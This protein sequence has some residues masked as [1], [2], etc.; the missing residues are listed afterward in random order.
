MEENR[1]PAPPVS[2]VPA[3][4]NPVTTQPVRAGMSKGGRELHAVDSTL[5]GVPHPFPGSCTCSCSAARYHHL[6]D[7]TRRPENPCQG[8]LLYSWSHLL[9]SMV[10]NISYLDHCLSSVH[11]VFQLQHINFPGDLVANF[12]AVGEQLETA[13]VWVEAAT[14]GRNRFPGRGTAAHRSNPHLFT[15]IPHT[16]S[17][18][19]RFLCTRFFT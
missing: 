2:M 4:Y 17:F 18:V 1:H 13:A 19:R 16:L 9:Y 11:T 6:H 14:G 3:S 8:H 5:S 12:P 15:T 10:N 7:L